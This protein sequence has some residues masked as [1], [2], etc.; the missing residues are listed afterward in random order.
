MAKKQQ[1]PAAPTRKPVQ[2]PAAPTRAAPVKQPTAKSKPVAAAAPP[3]AEA[4]NGTSGARGPRGVP[5]TAV[6]TLLV[7]ANPKRAGSKAELAFSQYQDGMTVGEFIDAVDSIAEI[8]GGATPNLVYDASHGF[9]EI[10]GYD[11]TLIIPKPKKEKVEAADKPAKK[12][13]GRKAEPEPDPDEQLDV[14]EE[15]IDGNE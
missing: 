4:G 3:P 12:A 10:E 13:K 2:P 5:E 14:Q 7:D 6:I 8:R 9:I 1:A 15:E 11:P